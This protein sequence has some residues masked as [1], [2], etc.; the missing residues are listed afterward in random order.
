MLTAKCTIIA[1]NHK[2][3]LQV[4]VL[5]TFVLSCGHHCLFSCAH[6]MFGQ[7]QIMENILSDGVTIEEIKSEALD[8]FEAK[9][10]GYEDGFVRFLPSGQV[11]Q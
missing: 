7:L 9:Q 4:F 5:R 3:V 10:T 6:P 11:N 1:T 2:P 8:M